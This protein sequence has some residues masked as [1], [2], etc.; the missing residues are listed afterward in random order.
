[1]MLSWLRLISLLLAL[2]LSSAAV[3]PS[4]HYS[5]ANI[6]FQK[7]GRRRGSSVGR[8]T[9]DYPLCRGTNQRLDS[10]HLVSTASPQTALP[11]YRDL[12]PLGRVVAGTVEIAIV[13]AT[14]FISGLMG[15]YVL[16]TLTDV[17]R[18]LFRPLDPQVQQP[19]WNEFSGRC[20]RL[21]SKS[22]KWGK[23]WASISATFGCTRVAVKVIRGGTEDEWN[24]IF[25]SM[26]AG[27]FFARNGT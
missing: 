20:M 5:V 17:P 21:H 24:T 25:S 8:S 3:Y 9:A 18:L 15:G 1:M 19:F 6:P 14:D 27:A 13:T 4:R 10:A 26:A 12:T 7:V 11:T 22:A 23:N 16:G 2:S